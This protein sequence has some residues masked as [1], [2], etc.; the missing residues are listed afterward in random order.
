MTTSRYWTCMQV[1]LWIE[2]TMYQIY[3]TNFT[4]IAQYTVSSCHCII[5]V[6][7]AQTYLYTNAC[8]RV[9]SYSTSTSLTKVSKLMFT[10]G[11][12]E[13]GS[14]EQEARKYDNNNNLLYNTQYPFITFRVSAW[15]MLFTVIFLLIKT[16]ATSGFVIANV[17]PCSE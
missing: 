15:S 8:T 5:T 6:S 17:W 11:R 14:S 3:N 9:I 12:C 16:L 13:R 7:L 4:N 1:C 2:N 10:P